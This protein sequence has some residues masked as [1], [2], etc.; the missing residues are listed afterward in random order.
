MTM[1]QQ[2]LFELSNAYL[3]HPYFVTGHAL[4]N[5]LARQVDGEIRRSLQ[6]STGVFVPGEYGEYP[7]EHSQDGYGGKIGKSLPTVERYEDL[8]LFRDPAQRWLLDSRPR[9]VHNVHDLQMYGGRVV[10]ASKCHFGRPP[11]TRN[12]KR[13]VQWFLHAYVH[14]D[15]VGVLPVGESVLDGIRVG[16]GR[17]YGLG[18]LSL[19]DTQLVDLDDLDYTG[20]VQSGQDGAFELELLSPYVLSTEYPAGDAQSVPWWWDAETGD[21][22][23][24]LRRRTTRLVN[25]DDTYSVETIDHGQVVRY[26]GDDP[27]KTAKNGIRRVGT[28]A[29]FGFGELRLRPADRDRV[30]ERVTEGGAG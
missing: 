23:P 25:G 2:V 5:A 28:H 20:I 7:E 30:P 14:S 27:V 6:V 29:R 17:N 13:S 10:F 18:E 9:D 19:A 15:D 12:T 3:G 4:Y 1:I 16:G 11:E 8:F 22:T 24:G 26:A 21:S